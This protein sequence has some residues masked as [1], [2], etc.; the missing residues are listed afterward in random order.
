MTCD[1]RAGG[2]VMVACDTMEG[3]GVKIIENNVISFMNGPIPH[4]LGNEANKI[5]K[6][7]NSCTH[8]G[9]CNLKEI[10]L[11]LVLQK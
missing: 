11:F 3:E 8:V 5:F 4:I 7:Y 1:K 2:G 9:K 6:T 10:Y